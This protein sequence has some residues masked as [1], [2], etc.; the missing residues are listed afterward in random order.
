MYRIIHPMNNNVAL[1][2]DEQQQELIVVGSGIAFGKKKNDLVAADKVEKVFRLK[3]DESRENF[4][5]LLK[6]VPLD[7]ITTTYEVIDS[8]SKKYA[9]PVQEYIYVTLTDH[10][11]CSYQAVT[12]GRYKESNL[13]DI[14]ENYPV[15]FEIA[16]EAVDIY[17]DKLTTSFP[18]DEVTRIAY[19]F[20]N[21]E[22]E[23]EVEVVDSMDQRKEI[24]KGVEE[25][26]NSYSIKRTEANNN[27]YDRFMIHLNYFLDYLDRNRNDNQSLLDMEEHIKSSYPLAFE[28]GSKIYDVISRE[29]GVDLYKSERVYLVLHIQRLL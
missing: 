6:D 3:T 28:I 26:L 7:F 27:F 13:L 14:S 16:K 23:N 20:I 29:T 15:A 9:Y 21:A 22:G 5:A 11:F 12:Q 24:L 2:Q 10:M 25:V 4:M 18:E 19:H 1:V 17:R 8:L